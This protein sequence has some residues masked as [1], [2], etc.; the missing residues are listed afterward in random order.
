MCV[1]GCGFR[2]T[3]NHLFLCCP[4]LDQIWHIVR[5]W[6]CVYSA[7]HF[8]Q[9]RTISGGDKSRCFLMHLVWFACVW[10]VKIKL[11]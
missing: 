7:D 3:E 9:F 8:N 6:L 10:G 2:E 11:K 4:L 5:N 1:A